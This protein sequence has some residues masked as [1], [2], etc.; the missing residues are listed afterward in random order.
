[1]EMNDG[2]SVNCGHCRAALA[3]GDKIFVMETRIVG[4]FVGRCLAPNMQHRS[5]FCA[6][7]YGTCNIGVRRGCP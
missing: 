3:W 5:I 4:G 7:C 2:Q 6:K 1:M